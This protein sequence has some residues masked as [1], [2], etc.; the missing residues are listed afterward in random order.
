[1][2]DATGGGVFEPVAGGLG[3]VELAVRIVSAAVLAGLVVAA[4]A[5]DGAVV[6]RD[7]EVDGPG[8]EGVG[9]LLI[10]GPE[11]GVAVAFLEQ[12]VLGGVVA[13][14]VEVGVGEVGL[15]AE[16]LRHTDA[17]ED[18]EHVLPRVHASPADF[19]FGGKAFAVV[20]GDGGGLFEGVDDAGGV[21]RGVFTPLGDAELGGVDADHAI[22]AHAVGVEDL[23]D[24]AGH[25]DGAEEFLLLSVVTH[26]GVA[27]GAGPHGSHEGTDGEAFGGDEISDAL[28]LVIAGLGIGVREEEEVVDAFELLAV[29]VGCGREVEH[30]LQADRGF[31]AVAIAFADEAGPHRVVKFGCGVAHDG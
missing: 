31:L 8:A 29:H 24:A 5:V 4:G 28:D 14:G 12:G 23:G 22:L 18:V 6:L 20:L 2:L 15:E 27:D 10:G 16:G 21:G 26:G 25:L 3:D 19:A 13:E 30:A 7:V 9:H 17:L 11:L 1:M